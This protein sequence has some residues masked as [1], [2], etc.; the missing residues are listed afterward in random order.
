MNLQLIPEPQVVQ[1]R[2]PELVSGIPGWTVQLQLPLKDVR[3]LTAAQRIFAEVTVRTVHDGSSVFSLVTEGTPLNPLLARRV[4]GKHDGYVLITDTDRIELYALSASGLFYGLKT[5]E[6]LLHTGGD[7]VPALTIADWAE[8]KLRS[9]YLDLRTVYPTYEHILEY[10]A[11]LADYKINTL[12]IEYEDKLPFRKLGF[13][14]HPELAFTEEEHQRLL[15][16]AHDHFVTVIPK[17][18][19]FGHLEYILKHPAYIGLREVPETVSELCP[20]RPGSFEMM[21]GILEEVA[22]LHPHS[23]YLHLGCDEVWTLGTCE[24]CK[25]SGLTPEASFIRFVNQLAE[26]TVSLGKQPMIW[27]DMIMHATAEEIAALDK[28]IV[29][30]VWIYGGHRMKADARLIL[31]KLRDAGIETL[32]A[33]SVRCWDDNGDQNYPV[34]HNRVKNVLDWIEL[35]RSEQLG[36]IIHTNWGVPVLA[37]QSLRAVRD[38]ALS[39]LPG[40]RAELECRGRSLYLPGPVS[41]PLPRTARRSPKRGR[42]GGLCGNRLLC[43]DPSAAAGGEEEP[44]DRRA[45]RR[46]DPV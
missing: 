9:D 18:Q 13:L 5:L 19:S 15:K 27:H 39:G 28:R 37:G 12:V 20:H 23:D 17:Q 31:H 1:S 4:E 8:L 40:R 25:R 30:V 42:M 38:L 44:L 6:Q 21:A 41:A 32:G 14:R 29:V 33:S 11:E 46:H 45:D 16:T 36:G 34:I 2:G 26:K 3:L 35:A 24:D 7:R 10:I 22:A 43:P